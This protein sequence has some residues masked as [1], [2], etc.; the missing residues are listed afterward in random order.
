MLS[1]TSEEL[2]DV[3]AL[4]CDSFPEED[5]L[6]PSFLTYWEVLE[7]VSLEIKDIGVMPESLTKVLI[8][9]IPKEGVIQMKCSIGAP[10]HDPQLSL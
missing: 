4:P 6:S 10:N 9:L 7:P 2:A 5:G 8:F 1:F 3:R